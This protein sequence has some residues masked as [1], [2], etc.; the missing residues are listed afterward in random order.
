[1]KVIRDYLIR[2]PEQEK[3]R[4]FQDIEEI[5]NSIYNISATRVSLF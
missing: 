1:M 5:I 3:R 2:L 4:L